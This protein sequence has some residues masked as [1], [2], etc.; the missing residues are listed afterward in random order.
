MKSSWLVSLGGCLILIAAARP[1]SLS[2]VPEK[3]G[4]VCREPV[5]AGYLSLDTATA[6]PKVVPY[7]PRAGDILL[8]DDCVKFHHLLFRIAGTGPPTHAAMI[9]DSPENKPVLLELTGPT[10]R[11]AKVVLMD[12]GP[13]LQSY[14]GT[15]MVRQTREPLTPEQSASLTEFALSQ[16]GK[17]LAFKRGLLQATPLC[18]RNGL[19]RVCFGHTYQN[20]R[21]WFCSEMV[22]VGACAARLLDPHI[23]PANIM[24]PRDLA[25]DETFNLSRVYEPAMRWIAAPPHPQSESGAWAAGY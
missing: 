10:V 14:Q 1:G 20:R 24:Y 25:F 19:R 23:Y 13:R 21:H 9:I 17:P 8:Y 3:G 7:C 2:N 15:I 22:V 12:V 5:Q 4:S 18:A 6:S 16:Q 11:S